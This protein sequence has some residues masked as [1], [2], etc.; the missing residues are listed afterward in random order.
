MAPRH[1]AEDRI[2]AGAKHLYWFINEIANIWKRSIL[3][4]KLCKMRMYFC[5]S[6]YR[7][8]F[9]FSTIK[10]LFIRRCYSHL[11]S[12]SKQWLDFDVYPVSSYRP[13]FT[14]KKWL[15]FDVYPTT[16]YRRRSLWPKSTIFRRSLDVAISTGFQRRSSDLISKYI[17]C[18]HI[19]LIST[20][21]KWLDFAT[22][23]ARWMGGVSDKLLTRF[24]QIKIYRREFFQS[25]N[26]YF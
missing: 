25:I 8:N 16:S 5:K 10:S 15:D 4:F 23:M 26:C 18:H 20:S 1:I 12:P 11:I 21:K 2:P 7:C 13:N 24:F 19:D 22:G 3:V 9:W 14:S 6:D 17:R